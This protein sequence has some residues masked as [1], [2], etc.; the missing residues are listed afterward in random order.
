MKLV[1]LVLLSCCLGLG[2]QVQTFT[3]TADPVELDSGASAPADMAFSCVS[4]TLDTFVA[5]YQLIF[6]FDQTLLDLVPA[7]SLAPVVGPDPAFFQSEVYNEITAVG[8][9]Q[10]PGGQ[11]YAASIFDFTMQ[12][13]LLFDIATPLCSFG[14]LPDVGVGDAATA[15]SLTSGITFSAGFTNAQSIVSYIDPFNAAVGFHLTSGTPI[16]FPVTVVAD[17]IFLRGDANTDGT[18]DI[19]DPVFMLFYF[20]VAGA[21]QPTC[22][23]SLDF[24]ADGTILWADE[25]FGLLGYLFQG[26]APAPGGDACAQQDPAGLTCLASGCP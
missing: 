14:V 23:A 22:L 13:L 21:D 3:V 19:T 26:G 1:S 7:V 12:N 6:T 4:N 5:G 24:S 20:F 15:L 9:L 8:G 2:A 25:V 10:F 18:L 16:D 17:P 11:A